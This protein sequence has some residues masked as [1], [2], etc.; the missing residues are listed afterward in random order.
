MKH[1]LRLLFLLTVLLPL[2][3]C[4][5]DKPRAYNIH[6]AYDA[7]TVDH[8]RIFPTVEID[9]VAADAATAEQLSKMEIDDYFDPANFI[10]SSLRK[11]TY[12]FSQ[13]KHDKQV[14]E[15]KDAIWKN[16]VDKRRCPYVVLFANLP[17]DGGK[18]PDL[19]RVKLPLAG[20]RWEGDDIEL[21]IVPSGLLLQTP[22]NPE[23]D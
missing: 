10:R 3:A 8:F 13:E 16:W 9:I 1:L 2:A 6:M 5:S 20:N 15:R 12:F 23:E 14:L 17:R 4:S 11:K 18:G 21:S 22:M 19:R 7:A